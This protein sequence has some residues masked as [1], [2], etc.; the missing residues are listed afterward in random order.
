[1]NDSEAIRRLLAEYCHLCD[2]A[3][4]AE[5]A[6]LFAPDGSFTAFKRTHTGHE[7]LAAFI[8]TAPLG[9]HL[10]FNAVID[11]EPERASCVSDFV[12]YTRA[13]EI[14]SVGRYI[15]DLIRTEAG[16][17][18]ASRRVEMMPAG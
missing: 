10:C 3:R 16:W 15:D 7:A 6:Q 18:Y 1:M 8:A 17:R 13:R 9:K 12:F 5:W 2:D 14:G 4:Y 11:L